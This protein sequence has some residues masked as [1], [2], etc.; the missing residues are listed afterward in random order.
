MQDTS[1]AKWRQF[2]AYC[3]RR[4]R[5]YAILDLAHNR[6]GTTGFSR[7]PLGALA[8]EGSVKGPIIKAAGLHKIYDTGP[9]KEEA[10]KQDRNRV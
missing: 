7:T 4:Q 8:E 2:S 5:S 3:S 9:V 6:Q 1:D 10:T